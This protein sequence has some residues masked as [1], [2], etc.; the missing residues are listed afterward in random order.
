MFGI[1]EDIEDIRKTNMITVMNH[2][3]DVDWMVGYCV[4]DRIKI[5]QVNV[6][7]DGCYEQL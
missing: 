4:G 3:G 5:L 7:G 6:D 1:A 2:R